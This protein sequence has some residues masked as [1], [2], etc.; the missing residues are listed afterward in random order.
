MDAVANRTLEAGSAGYVETQAVLKDP[1]MC[2]SSGSIHPGLEATPP[3]QVTAFGP[4]RSVKRVAPQQPFEKKRGSFAKAVRAQPEACKMDGKEVEDA[5]SASRLIDDDNEGPSNGTV[6]G[7][8][9]VMALCLSLLVI[10][11]PV[12]GLPS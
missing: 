11:P 2:S 10:F 4:I 9:W 3:P 12:G 7:L 5:S 8:D 1:Y 6:V